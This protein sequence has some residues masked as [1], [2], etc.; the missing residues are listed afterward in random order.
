LNIAINW[1]YSQLYVDTVRARL[2]WIDF[3]LSHYA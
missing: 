2:S 1:Q 3:I